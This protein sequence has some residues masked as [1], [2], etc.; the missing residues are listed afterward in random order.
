MDD[1]TFDRL[2]RALSDRRSRRGVVQAISVALA[3][4]ASIPGADLLAKRKGG[5][6]PKKGKSKSKKKKQKKKQKGCKRQRCSGGMEFDMGSCQCR[7]PKDMRECRDHCVGRDRCCPSDPPCATDPKGCCHSPGVEVCTNDGC[8]LELNGMKAC[9]LFC[10]DTNT[11]LD[12]CGD[13]WV[14][15]RS[16][17]VCIGGNC[18]PTTCVNG[19]PA[20]G[21]TCCDPGELCCNGVCRFQGTAI[22]TADGW[23]PPVTG[24][25]CCGSAGCAEGPCCNIDIEACCPTLESDG[26]VT[27][28][29]CPGNGERCA[30]GGCCPAGMHWT[31]DLGCDACCPDGFG[32][33]HECVAPV[34]GRG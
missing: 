12:H 32:H 15:C 24:H 14:R 34:P 9:D 21:D 33:C 4:L 27:T 17:E 7:C 6:T 26:S 25:A 18:R 30:P 2:T 10:V 5:N 16:D 23:C 1:H 8:C 19:E 31:S 20:C 3:G 11:S 22:C 13:C 28:T 29:C